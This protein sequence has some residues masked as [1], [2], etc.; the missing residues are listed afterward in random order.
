VPL[1]QFKRRIREEEAYPDASDPGWIEKD[2]I[3]EEK[4]EYGRGV[5]PPPAQD[6]VELRVPTDEPIPTVLAGTAPACKALR[7]FARSDRVRDPEWV[8]IVVRRRL[9]Q[10]LDAVPMMADARPLPFD[11]AKVRETEADGLP[12]LVNSVLVLLEWA[13]GQAE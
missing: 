10:L 4:P 11:K 12:A 8:K 6:V 9:D 5:F 1:Y 7:D 13:D 2:E 3:R